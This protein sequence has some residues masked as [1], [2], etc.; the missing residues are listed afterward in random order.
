M[1]ATAAGEA[2]TAVQS[3]ASSSEV[4]VPTGSFFNGTDFV[5]VQKGWVRIVIQPQSAEYNYTAQT[6][7]YG[8][9]VLKLTNGEAITIYPNGRALIYNGVKYEKKSY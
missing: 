9:I 5:Y 6:D 8:N 3:T 1:A 2:N 7:N 4:N